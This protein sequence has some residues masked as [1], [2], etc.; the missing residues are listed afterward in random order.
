MSSKVTDGFACKLLKTK[1][2]FAELSPSQTKGKAILVYALLVSRPK[3][4]R[5]ISGGWL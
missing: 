3:F 2:S 1:L 4:E 5:D